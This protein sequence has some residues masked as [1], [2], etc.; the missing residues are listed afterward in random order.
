MND[1]LDR[2]AH[3]GRVEENA[4]KRKEKKRHRQ[5]GRRAPAAQDQN[6]HTTRRITQTKTTHY[7]PC[8][9]VVLISDHHNASLFPLLPTF[10]A[11]RQTSLFRNF[12]PKDLHPL[13]PT[14]LGNH[15]V[16]TGFPENP[17]SCSCQPSRRFHFL[18][19]L[20]RFVRHPGAGGPSDPPVESLHSL[21]TCSDASPISRHSGFSSDDPADCATRPS[22]DFHNFVPGAA[23]MISRIVEYIL[24][25]ATGLSSSFF[26][27]VLRPFF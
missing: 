23:L 7:Q 12:P 15:E 19:C 13:L 2:H 26:L 8:L 14:N 21:S 25:H 5:T 4:K 24:D 18:T 22:L 1:S 27:Q 3:G 16:R 6:H 10:P 11:S 9:L 20:L 17:S